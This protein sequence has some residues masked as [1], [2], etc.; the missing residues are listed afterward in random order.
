MDKKIFV[1]CLKM[2]YYIWRWIV[3][4]TDNW[5]APNGE[6]TAAAQKWASDEKGWWIQNPDGVWVH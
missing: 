6:G 2:R 4:L 3:H 1:L 5:S